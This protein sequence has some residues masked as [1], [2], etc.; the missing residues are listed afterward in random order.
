MAAVPWTKVL[1]VWYPREAIQ[2]QAPVRS[3]Y[4]RW[5]SRSPW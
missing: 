1:V 2:I 3:R 4:F 5:H